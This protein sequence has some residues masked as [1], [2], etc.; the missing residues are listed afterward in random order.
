MGHQDIN[1]TLIYARVYDQTVR[2]QFAM[3]MAQ[4]EQIAVPA[5]WPAQLTELAETV[6]KLNVQT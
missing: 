3:A 4:V 1:K 6:T 5:A 2:T